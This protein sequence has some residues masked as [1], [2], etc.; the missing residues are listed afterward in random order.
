MVK[1]GICQM[2][3]GENK[4]A[5]MNKAEQM[6]GDAASEGANMVVLPEMFNCPYDNAFFPS[7][8]EP[9]NGETVG[10][11]SE[12]AHQHH[13]YLIGGSIP[14]VED[15]KIY[16]TCYVFDP[17]GEILGKYRKIHLFDVDIA[18]GVRFKESDTL[19]AGDEPLVVE[20]AYGKIGVGICYDIRFPE[21]ARRMALDG[22]EIIFLPGA[23][24]MTTGPAHWGLSIKMRAVDNQVYFVGAS[25]ARDEQASYVA[26]GHSM[27][28][29]P[30]GEV[31][32]EAGAKEGIVYGEL[33][34]DKIVK[35]RQELPLL[36]HRRT[37]IY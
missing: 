25:P 30:W 17:F 36:A 33:D 34:R 2:L 26:Y 31:I 28:A 15:G 19:T 23:F 22:A 11:L 10:R 20:T 9:P 12:M 3:V 37:D 7:R 6:V 27:I 13:V 14:E 29:D 1:V 18:G 16:N 21:L 4:A 8:A 5:N 35:T 24:N 32:V